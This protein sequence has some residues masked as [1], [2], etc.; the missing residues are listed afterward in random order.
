METK[1]H[2]RRGTLGTAVLQ[3]PRHCSPKTDVR[4]RP[5]MGL[6]LPESTTTT[7]MDE[8]YQQ[9]HKPESNGSK[10]V[11]NTKT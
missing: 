6:Q 5:T 7:T 1:I 3:Q 10:H 9:Y 8:I 4:W 2:E 11:S